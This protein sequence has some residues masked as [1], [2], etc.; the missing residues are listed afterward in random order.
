MAACRAGLFHAGF[1]AAHRSEKK[2]KLPLRAGNIPCLVEE[3]QGSAGMATG[4]H[5][6]WP[7]AMGRMPSIE[8]FTE[9]LERSVHVK[10]QE[11]LVAKCKV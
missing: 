6:V 9:E 3:V 5:D 10:E 8:L 11:A 1:T 2:E 7:S 4:Q